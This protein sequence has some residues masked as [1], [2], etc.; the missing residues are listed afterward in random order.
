VLF[1]QNNRDSNN[2]KLRGSQYIAAR[3]AN[4]KQKKWCRALESPIVK[5]AA[6]FAA[7]TLHTQVQLSYMEVYVEAKHGNY[8]GFRNDRALLSRYWLDKSLL[9]LGSIVVTNDI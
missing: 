1:G 3:A 4:V 7:W 6:E 5:K 9:L 2:E 8:F